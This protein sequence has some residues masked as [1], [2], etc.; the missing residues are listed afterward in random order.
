MQAKVKVFTNND[1][2]YVWWSVPAKIPGCLGFSLHREIENKAPK[3]LPAW[4]GFDKGAK[5]QKPRDTDVWPIQSFQWK[6]VYAP[7]QGRFRYHIYAVRGTP[8]APQR[9]AAPIIVTPFADLDEQIG[10][11]RVVFNRGLLST[12]A[13]NRGSNAPAKKVAKLRKDIGTPGNA[14]RWR[15][16]KELLPTMRDL[17]QRARSDGGTCYSALYELT[18]EEMIAD[19]EATAGTDLVL[20]NANSSKMVSGKSKTVYDGTNDDTRKRL[21]KDDDLHVTDRL[22]K[23]NSIGHNKFIVYADSQRQLQSVLTGSANWTP[24]G[25]C[26]Q[27]NNALLIDDQDLA[28]H[29]HAYWTHLRNEQAELQGQTLRSWARANPKEISLGHG[30]GTL[31]VWFSPNTKAKTKNAKVTPADMQEVYDIV[32]GAKKAIL[33]LVF[34]PGTPSI[35]D[36]IKE[37]AKAKSKKKKPIYVRGAIS[38]PKTA[39]AGAVRVFSRAANAPSDTVITGASGVPDDFGYWEKEL[40]KL[41]HAAIHDKILVVDPFSAKDCVVVTGSHNLGFKASYANDENMVI[42]RGNARIAE[43]FAAHVLDVVNHYKWRYR[44]QTLYRK[45]KLD[46]AWQDLDDDDS[47]QDKY[48]DSG[49]L[50]SRDRFILP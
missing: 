48:F 22:L 49:F 8:A 21:H 35:I 46:E 39:T 32:A 40:L 15:L 9:D 45:G 50:A 6:D 37:V 18:D 44:L 23:G 4:V 20:S 12:Q 5:G 34:N 31:K 38:D 36:K 17:L 30:A 29:Y 14:I 27:T 33:F 11:V 43:A 25:V 10:M 41:G 26:G 16:G 42:I 3:A 13:L 7:R 1:I 47:W 2:A 28:S 19:L 24:T